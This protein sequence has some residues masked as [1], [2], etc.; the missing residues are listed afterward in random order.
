MS[1]PIITIDGDDLWYSPDDGGYY[2]Q[3]D[4][5]PDCPT[6]QVFRTIDEAKRARYLGQLEWDEPVEDDQ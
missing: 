1:K 3:N 4:E 2:W 5:Y 6:S